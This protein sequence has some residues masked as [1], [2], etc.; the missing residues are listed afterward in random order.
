MRRKHE[1]WDILPEA[2]QHENDLS[3]DADKRPEKT[4]HEE[5]FVD[6]V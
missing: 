3:K 6:D 2:Q 1:H 4:V 5:M